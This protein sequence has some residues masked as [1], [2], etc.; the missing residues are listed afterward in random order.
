MKFYSKKAKKKA[1]LVIEKIIA[2]RGDDQTIDELRAAIAEDSS[3]GE[4]ERVFAALH[5]IAIESG[6]YGA[7]ACAL[8]ALISF[9]PIPDVIDDALESRM[10]ELSTEKDAMGNKQLIEAMAIYLYIRVSAGVDR[11]KPFMGMLIAF[12]D[13]RTGVAASKAYHTLMIVAA[14]RPESFAQHSGGLIRLLGSINIPTRTYSAKLIAV[15]ASSHPE[16]FPDAEN[17]L[18]NLSTNPH[19]EVKS[20]ASEAYQILTRRARSE[21]ET[22]SKSQPSPMEEQKGGLADIMRRKSQD[23][24]KP[25]GESRIDN[26]LLSMATNFARKAGR[27]IDPEE[28]EVPPPAPHQDDG[29]AYTKIIDDFSAIAA[30]IKSEGP[31]VIPSPVPEQ[32]VAAAASPTPAPEPALTEEEELRDMMRRVEDD[33]SITAGSILDALGIGHLAKDEHDQAPAPMPA[34]VERPKHHASARVHHV[35][36][37][38]ATEKSVAPSYEDAAEKELTSREFIASIES[39]IRRTELP[40]PEVAPAEA[41]AAVEAPAPAIPEVAVAP[42]VVDEPVATLA[43]EPV[44]VPPAA[45]E[46][47]VAQTPE[48]IQIPVADHPAAAQPPEPAIPDAADLAPA[49]KPG[50]DIPAIDQGK[51]VKSPIIPAGVRISAMKFKTIDQTKKPAPA[52]ISIKPH[53]KPLN[54]TPL[55]QVKGAQSRQQQPA[56]RGPGTGAQALDVTCP[57]CNT[58]LSEDCTRCVVCGADVKSPKVRCRRCGEINPLQAGNCSRCG[59]G[60][61]GGE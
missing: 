19:P 20:A 4:T 54:K 59:S 29:E 45:E 42:P 57:S 32:P 12:L 31:A 51:H 22:A 39:M 40:A 44:P 55:D 26:R 60:L 52:K 3:P 1:D 53:I 38:P 15:V 14:N 13:E 17:T 24:V 11:A 10:L 16:F 48:P 28:E 18:Y 7:V 50:A 58:R 46:T 2:G 8:K 6:N 33:F 30:S 9:G 41:P 25:S 37:E 35:K 27:A 23:K 34:L 56:S 43:P 61:N 49:E 36:K 47:A 21:G 5:E